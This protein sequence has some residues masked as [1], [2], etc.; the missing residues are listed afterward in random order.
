MR[1]RKKKIKLKIKNILLFLLIILL[2]P[3]SITYCINPEDEELKTPKEEEPKIKT[4]EVS[5]VM[6]GDALKHDK[7]Y[8]EAKTLGSG[9]NDFKPMLS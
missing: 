2:I 9:T 4:Y 1:K 7:I 8:N 5:L 6:V 3:V